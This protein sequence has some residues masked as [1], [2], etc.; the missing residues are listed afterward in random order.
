MFESHP[1][2]R[3]I[4]NVTSDTKFSFQHALP[5]GTYQTIMQ[6]NKNKTTSGNFPTKALKTIA[7]DISVPLTDF[8]N[9]ANLNGVFCYELKLADVTPLYRKSDPE[10][11]TNY[12]PISIIPSL[13]KV[14][15]KISRK[16]L[17]SLFKTKA[18]PDSCA[19]RSR[20]ST[21]QLY[22]TFSLIGKTV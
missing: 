5:W 18:S 15:E 13:S 20:Y 12:R 7:R 21:E 2:V 10:D 4:K 16:Q 9:S 11:K 8:I 14:Y 3:H 1:S 6:L 19:F 22:L 17:N